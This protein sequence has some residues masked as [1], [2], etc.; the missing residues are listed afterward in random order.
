MTLLVP[1]K[2]K[3]DLKEQVGNRLD[4]EETIATWFDKEYKSNGSFLVT[5]DRRSYFAKVT[6]KDDVIVRV[7]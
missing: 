2:T 5:N 1:N 3:K 7:E 6:M 4:Y